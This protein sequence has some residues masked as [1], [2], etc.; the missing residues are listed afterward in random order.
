MRFLHEAETRITDERR[1][2][3]A[4]QGDGRPF[5][6]PS[7]QHDSGIAFVVF[8]QRKKRRVDAEMPEQAAGVTGILGR[9]EVDESLGGVVAKI[10]VE[11]D[12]L[13]IEGG[14]PGHQNSTVVVRGAVK[15][16]NAGKKKA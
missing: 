5:P 13:L 1:S 16:K 11:D 2:G 9:D 4:D 10:I 14:V 8:V 3:V 15:K 6:E 12:L 7:K